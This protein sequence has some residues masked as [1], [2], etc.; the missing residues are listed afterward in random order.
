[1]LLTTP[2]WAADIV[3]QKMWSVRRIMGVLLVPFGTLFLLHMVKHAYPINS[4]TGI[5][6][7]GL[8]GFDVYILGLSFVAVLVYLHLAGWTACVIGMQVQNRA[9]AVL[10]TLSTITCW[11]FLLP[12]LL[13]VFFQ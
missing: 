3:L 6:Q 8:N 10:A 7:W 2:I 5:G 12:A 1:M 11:F 4:S 13:M 9:Y